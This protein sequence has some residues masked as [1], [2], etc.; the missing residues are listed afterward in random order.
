[1]KPNDRLVNTDLANNRDIY[2]TEDGSYYARTRW[3]AILTKEQ[4]HELT[5]TDDI[6]NSQ[7]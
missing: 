6:N 3:Q 2:I 4:E 5:K 1:M 7:L